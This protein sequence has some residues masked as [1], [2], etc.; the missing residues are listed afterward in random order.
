[1]KQEV[2]VTTDNY[3]DI[4]QQLDYL[5][6]Y[7]GGIFKITVSEKIENLTVKDLIYNAKAIVTNKNIGSKIVITDTYVLVG[8]NKYIF[9]NS[10]SKERIKKW[11]KSQ[12]KDKILL[13]SYIRF[14]YDCY[15]NE[16]SKY[17]LF[18][19]ILDYL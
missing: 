4:L 12:I 2:I 10:Y 14:N 15:L 17:E 18:E 3:I 16:L 7:H 11:L 13:D 8:N 5:I 6:Y 9:L 19:I 1:M